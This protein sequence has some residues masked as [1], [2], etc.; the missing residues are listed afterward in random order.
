MV[1]R[2]GPLLLE[3]ARGMGS[4]SQQSRLCGW[5]SDG[6]RGG[7]GPPRRRQG[8]SVTGREEFVEYMNHAVAIVQLQITRDGMGITCEIKAIPDRSL[9]LVVVTER[10]C[11]VNVRTTRAREPYPR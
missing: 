5:C 9:E 6:L 11:F 4:R 10:A 8:K 1:A 3:H 7:G 2:G